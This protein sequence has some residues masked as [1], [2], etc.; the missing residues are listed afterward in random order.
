[1]TKL[2][3]MVSYNYSKIC[4]KSGISTQQTD[5]LNIVG[6]VSNFKEIFHHNIYKLARLVH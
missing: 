2:Q 4:V 1:M 6:K 5:A 3:N